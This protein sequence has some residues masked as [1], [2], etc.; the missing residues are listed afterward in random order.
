[1]TINFKSELWIYPGQNAWYFVSVPTE[2]YADLKEIS[3]QIKRGF[4]SIK[5]EVT[6]GKST[7]NT[8]IF[9]DNSRQTF[10]LPVKKQV[11]ANNDII[12]GDNIKVAIRVV[13]G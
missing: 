11:R 13:A 9:P 8:S 12:A 4:G 3:S 6:V 2:Y 7:W 1:M 10:L 5:V